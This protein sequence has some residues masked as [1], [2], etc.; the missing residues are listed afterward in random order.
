MKRDYYDILGVSRTASFDDIKKAYRKLALRYHPD[1]NPNDKEAEEKFKEAAEAYEVLRDPEKRKVYD[2]HG[3][4]GIT[5]MGFSGFTRQEDIF[6]AFNDLFGDF[7]GFSTSSRSQGSGFGPEQGADLR[8]D[9]TISFE[10]AARGTEKNIKITRLEP[11]EKCNGTGLNPGSQP[12]ICNLCKG[13]G[14]VI[15]TEGFFR[16]A[17]TCPNCKGRGVIITNPCR[18]CNGQGRIRKHQMVKV[19][20]PAGADNGSKLRLRGEGEAGLR[21]GPRGDLYIILHVEPHEFFER[22]GNDIYCRIQISMVQAA[23]GDEID[24]L[25]L[26]GQ[27]KF[28]IPAGTQPG[29]TF[30]LKGLGVPDL[31]GFG[32]GDQIIE[33][34]I[35]IPKKLTERQK[36]LLREFASLEK[37]ED[38]GGI[39]KRFFKRFE[40]HEQT[41][42]KE[43]AV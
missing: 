4:E 33:I 30:R 43:N 1:R 6:S 9:L 16:I 12:A 36:E 26:D 13:R 17:T 15:H 24:V 10:E 18:T 28:K 7:F 37:E 29:E 41:G 40:D 3:H 31:R 8:Y 20:I 42:K 38:E 22:H 23:L 21:G 34:S 5:G 11:C 35:V 2:L 19:R 27:R 14:Q 25:T 39:F 32:T